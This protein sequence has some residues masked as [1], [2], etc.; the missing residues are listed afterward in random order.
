MH[1]SVDDRPVANALLKLDVASTQLAVDGRP[2]KHR[3]DSAAALGHW[4]HRLVASTML[5]RMKHECR[6]YVALTV[7]SI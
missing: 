7:A 4:G 2:S 3:E 5:A 1:S 6:S